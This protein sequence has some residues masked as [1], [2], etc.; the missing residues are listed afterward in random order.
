MPYE[1]SDAKRE[2]YLSEGAS[3]LAADLA[4][5]LMVYAVTA[6]NSDEL[7]YIP[8]PVT[9]ASIA[10]IEAK[11]A[12]RPGQV[13][14]LQR[15]LAGEVDELEHAALSRVRKADLAEAGVKS[16][17]LIVMP[18]NIGYWEG[19]FWSHEK[20]NQTEAAMGLTQEA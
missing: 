1:L 9:A 11:L 4:S 3:R 14:F 6:Y 15:F 5:Y 8:R 2:A 18:T 17:S 10:E 12:A 16:R 13:S 20:F 7:L 19:G